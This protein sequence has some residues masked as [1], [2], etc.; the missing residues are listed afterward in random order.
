MSK[1]ILLILLLVSFEIQAQLSAP[2]L[3]ITTEE[4]EV[5]LSWST[6]DEALGY[7]LLYAPYP[8]QGG[9]AIETIDMGNTTSFTVDL[10]QG[11]AFYVAIQAY[12]INH[13]NSGYS[14]IGFFQIKNRGEVDT[15]P[16]VIKLNDT[17][18]TWSGNYPYRNNATCIG[19]EVDKQ[20]CS[21]GRDAQAAA[22]TLTKIGAGAAGFDF[23]KLDSNG[24]T[25]PASASSWACVKDNHTGLIW[26]VKTTDGGIHDKNNTYQWGGLSAQGRDHA[27]KL[28]TY[29]DDWN[30][31]VEG[32]NSNNFCGFNTGWRVPNATELRSI[33]HLGRSNPSIDSDY[34]P[35]TDAS[36]VWS[37]SP[38]AGGAYNAWYIYFVNGYTGYLNRYSYFSVR[39]VRSGQ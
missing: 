2:S 24:N 22:G 16:P 29:Y 4:L 23:T 11:A 36:V 21:Y 33:V 19:T 10:W 38:Y 28:G 37:S 7:K 13:Q 26:E 27:S 14:N 12:D 5:S 34:F 35:N 31:L 20:D 3:H 18:I 30:T 32:S 9:Q 6:N 39:L 15:I 25:L 8:Y 17:G 1:L